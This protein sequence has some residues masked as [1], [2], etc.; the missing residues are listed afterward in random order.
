VQ[1][2]YVYW[3]ENMVVVV[4]FEERSMR[5]K[6]VSVWGYGR[7]MVALGHLETPHHVLLGT[8]LCRHNLAVGG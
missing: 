1:A 8:W 2:G 3:P 6:S 5:R 4:N 7:Y